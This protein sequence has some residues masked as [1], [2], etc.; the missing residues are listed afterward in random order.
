MIIITCNN[1]FKYEHEMTRRWWCVC[2]KEFRYKKSEL[3][4]LWLN[5]FFFCFYNN[6]R[7]HSSLFRD[8]GQLIFQERHTWRCRCN[9]VNMMTLCIRAKSSG[10]I[11]FSS[12]HKVNMC[13]LCVTRH[14]IWEEWLIIIMIETFWDFFCVARLFFF[15][16]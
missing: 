15:C 16:G 13:F 8:V 6:L 9:K 5:S 11:K 7:D 4:P 2:V 3:A 12:T 14:I 10:S 1:L